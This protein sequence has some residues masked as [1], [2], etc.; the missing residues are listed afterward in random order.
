LSV[1]EWFKRLSAKRKLRV[2]S[3]WET[4]IFVVVAYLSP[5]IASSN[6]VQFDT[7][8]FS[9]AVVLSVILNIIAHRPRIRSSSNRWVT[10]GNRSIIWAF[11]VFFG[12]LAA[13]L[14]VLLGLIAQYP[15]AVVGISVIFLLFVFE[16]IYLNKETDELVKP[17]TTAEERQTKRMTL[18]HWISDSTKRVRE[19][20]EK[21]PRLSVSAIAIFAGLVVI[22]FSVG[23][24]RQTLGAAAQS[25]IE[26]AAFLAGA[27]GVM[28]AI[29]LG[30]VLRGISKNATKSIPSWNA[31]IKK[32]TI[33][34]ASS[35]K[36]PE[37][38]ARLTQELLNKGLN[39]WQDSIVGSMGGARLIRSA[40]SYPI[41][42]LVASAIS[43]V[44]VIL[45]GS[46]LLFGLSVGLMILATW[47]IFRGWKV[48]EQTMHGVIGEESILKDVDPAQMK[49]SYAS[50]NQ[51]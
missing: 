38:Q 11:G 5:Y 29:Y 49:I 42:F 41:S 34:A 30:Q 33:E 48:G 15:Y 4:G 39:F 7:V 6:G 50:E 24:D 1:I 51:S 32:A 2:E 12:A 31:V 37:S 13:G 17:K 25:M 16:T 3:V 8:F 21:H 22:Y 36:D 27:S 45:S 40:G 23:D 43:A 44:L 28:T 10:F 35:A 9:A 26:L 47:A 19:F 18:R 14:P 20:G 46:V